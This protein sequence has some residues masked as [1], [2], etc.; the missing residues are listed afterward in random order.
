[1]K[2]SSPGGIP[3]MS[4]LSVKSSGKGALLQF[5]NHNGNTNTLGS[6]GKNNISTLNNNH[7]QGSGGN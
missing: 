7:I 1:M 2:T 3:E 6:T 5:N 4:A